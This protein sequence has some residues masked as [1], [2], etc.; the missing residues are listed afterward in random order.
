M[1][2][3]DGYVDNIDATVTLSVCDNEDGE[4]IIINLDSD[5]LDAVGIA[6]SAAQ[7]FALIDDLRIL[8]AGI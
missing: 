4:N 1:D 3:I 8:A 6:L 7:V 5:N 2:Y